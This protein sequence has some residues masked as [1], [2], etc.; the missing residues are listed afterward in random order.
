[1]SKLNILLIEDE[2][3]I[4]KDIKVTLEQNDF[5]QVEVALKPEQAKEKFS[6]TTFDLIISDVNLNADIDGID[7]VKELCSVKKL[8]I[9]YLSAYADEATIKKAE[10]SLPY[11]YL[12][13]PYNTNQLK[14]TVNLAIL[15]AKEEH[16]WIEYDKKNVDLLKT[17][18]K[19][20]Q[21]ILFVLASGKLSKETGDLLNIATST[22]EKHK[23]NIKE[24]LNLKT[25][26]ELV[27]FALSTKT[28]SMD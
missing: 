8:P 3:I 15:N 5:A 14:M 20:E 27:N 9:V 11:A 1:M 18:T 10:Q 22:V 28:V 24:K 17:L 4:A 7:L 13:K 19:R 12:L 6:A 23:Q 2:A 21:E 16:E 26:G 25:I